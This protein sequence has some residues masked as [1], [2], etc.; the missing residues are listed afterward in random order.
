[1]GGS[2]KGQEEGRKRGR[3]DS[4]CWSLLCFTFFL[5]RTP[6]YWRVLFTFMSWGAPLSEASGNMDLQRH[7]GRYL[8][9]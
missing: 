2:G 8:M 1:M 7:I 4:R 6:G 9:S 3:V 5:S